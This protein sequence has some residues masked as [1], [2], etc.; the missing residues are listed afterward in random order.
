MEAEDNYTM[1][2]QYKQIESDE[3]YLLLGDRVDLR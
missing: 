1:S 2:N 3:V